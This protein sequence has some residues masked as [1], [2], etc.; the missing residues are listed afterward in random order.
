MR[1]ISAD[2]LS[3]FY[4]MMAF[5][6]SPKST[7]FGL[8]TRP[9]TAHGLVSIRDFMS[10]CWT[11]ATPVAPHRPETRLKATRSML[12]RPMHPHKFPR[13]SVIDHRA[14]VL[15]GLSHW[16]PSSPSQLAKARQ[17]CA[18]GDQA[19]ACSEARSSGTRSLISHS[20]MDSFGQ[21]LASNHR[22]MN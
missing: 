3:C 16:F 15:V 9:V 5:S 10:D 17:G 4:E 8:N 14:A 2:A 6:H 18:R 21:R 22:V 7:T 11:I 1:F 19:C 20:G 12:L 13:R